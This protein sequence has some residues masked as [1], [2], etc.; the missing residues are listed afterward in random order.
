MRGGAIAS[1]MTSGVRHRI[2]SA[3]NC[4]PCMPNCLCSPYPQGWRGWSARSRPDR[5]RSCMAVEAS[6]RDELLAAIPRLRTFAISFTNNQDRADDLVQE[7]ILR[8]W[9]NIDKFEP[10]T[11][12]HAWLFTI[13]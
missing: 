11:N 3:R 1:G 4:G 6:L 8:A 10:G 5:R 13:L 12:L 2:G 9:A 7:T